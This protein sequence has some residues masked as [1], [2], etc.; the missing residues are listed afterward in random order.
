MSDSAPAPS[1]DH[2]ILTADYPHLFHKDVRKDIL[3]RV[4]IS[5]IITLLI[6]I[7]MGLIIALQLGATWSP[8][9]FTQ[10]ID[11]VV[12][13]HD[14]SI[15]GSIL[16]NIL[17][18]VT[19]LSIRF[20]Y[21][22]DDPYNYIL[23]EGAWGAL[24]IPENFT[25]NFYAGLDGQKPYSQSLSYIFDQGRHYGGIN[26]INRLLYAY[27]NASSTVIIDSLAKN[28]KG[29]ILTTNVDPQ[30]LFNPVP[31]T[32]INI[33]P[34]THTGED[35]AVSLCMMYLFL[36]ATA[37]ASNVSA[38]WNVLLGKVRLYQILLIRTAHNF[39]N[40]VLICLAICMIM[41]AFGS[42]FMSGIVPFWL[43]LVLVMLTF[44]QIVELIV[45]TCGPFFIFL[46]PLAMV[47]NYA[48]SQ[49]MMPNEL[50]SSFYLMGKA[51]PMYHGVRGARFLL[52][53]SH[54]SFIAEDVA[55]LAAWF[56]P[57][58]VINCSVFMFPNL[59]KRYK[60]F[61]AIKKSEKSTKN[62]SHDESHQETH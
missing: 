39:I 37:S 51:L 2:A 22:I 32:E 46:Y 41:F 30:I 9:S 11:I 52:F 61:S 54:K 47:L 25:K 44:M 50:Q 26:V 24:V 58:F 15:V 49:A 59:F 14:Q 34:I 19:G 31:I 8:T 40:A 36:L 18:N 23:T 1:H 27:M 60:F 4:V 43:Y 48:T 28:Y 57:L 33:R 5:F 62:D 21:T 53:G 42:E 12:V 56:I 17:A 16:Q 29:G 35:G 45:V 20:D 7:L 55:V 6:L 3:R 38:L 13:D 10:N